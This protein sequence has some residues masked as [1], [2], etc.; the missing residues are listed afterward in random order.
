MAPNKIILAS[1]ILSFIAGTVA[2]STLAEAHIDIC[3][4]STNGKG[5]QELWAAVCDLQQQ[6]DNIQLIPGPQGPPGPTGATGL[7]GPPGPTGATG[8]QGPPG[9]PC[10]ACVDSS[11]IAD[12]SV[13]TV[14]I[15]NGAITLAKLAANSVNSANIVD[16]SIT[17]VDV[18][19]TAGIAFSK[20][21][22]TALFTDILVGSKSLTATTISSLADQTVAVTVTGADTTN[23]VVLCNISSNADFDE[24]MITQ[25]RITALNTVS[26]TLTNPTSGSVTVDSTDV[27]T[28]VVFKRP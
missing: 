1:I 16:G 4:G 11:S 3:K 12:G 19:A 20:I 2:S 25:A 26:V 23:D 8:L 14:D 13:A 10:N 22:N 24:I 5:F 6:I 15:V 21:A 18:S 28:C 17:N 9:V 7:Q 27:I